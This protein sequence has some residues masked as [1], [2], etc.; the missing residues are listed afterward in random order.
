ML[1][2]AGRSISSRS[3]QRNARTSTMARNCSSAML[4]TSATF[5]I[6]TMRRI[7][8]QPANPSAS[9]NSRCRKRAR[10]ASALTPLRSSPIK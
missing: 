5:A 6:P 4:V 7:I 9:A 1:R 10:N 3:A 2:S 8:L